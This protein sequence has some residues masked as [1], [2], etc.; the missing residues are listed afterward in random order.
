MSMNTK[1][2]IQKINQA[3]EDVLSNVKAMYDSLGRVKNLIDGSK[4]YFDSPAGDDLRKKFNQS[5]QKFGEF[6]SFLNTYGEFL[7]TFSENYR[8]F[9]GE[10]Q[11]AVREIPTL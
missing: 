3:G 7:K 1:L 2:D 5:A 9:E 10:V 6:Q 11:D 4:S 8:D